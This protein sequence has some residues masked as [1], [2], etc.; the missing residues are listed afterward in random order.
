MITIAMIDNLAK[1]LTAETTRTCRYGQIH[2]STNYV[3][4]T[5]SRW[6]S[7]HLA[8]AI[9][10]VLLTREVKIRKSIRSIHAYGR[11]VRRHNTWQHYPV[12]AFVSDVAQ[13]LVYSRRPS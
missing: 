12:S 2:M 9:R 13:C 1:R 4:C 6:R 7:G 10:R 11:S 5:F 8:E 3:N